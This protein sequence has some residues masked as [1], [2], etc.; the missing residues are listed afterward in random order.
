MV[1][2]SMVEALADAA[3]FMGLQEVA[4]CRCMVWKEQ[5]LFQLA[6]VFGLCPLWHFFILAMQDVCHSFLRVEPSDI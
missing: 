5:G 4:L 1:C 2:L 3:I 6:Y